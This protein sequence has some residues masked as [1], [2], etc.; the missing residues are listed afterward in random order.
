MCTVVCVE[1]GNGWLGMYDL[2]CFICCMF[3]CWYIQ[4][5]YSC[6]SSYFG[7]VCVECMYPPCPTLYGVCDTVAFVCMCLVCVGIWYVSLCGY[8]CVCVLALY[9]QMWVVVRVCMFCYTILGVGVNV[10]YCI[11]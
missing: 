7:P 2:V 5:V 9:V 1:V 6:L 3:C 11:R 8:V 10:E 4:V